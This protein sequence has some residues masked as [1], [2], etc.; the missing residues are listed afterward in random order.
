MRIRNKRIG[1]DLDSKNR[2]RLL[3]TYL[4]AS[5]YGK[6]KVYE[7]K[8]GYHIII[9][10]PWNNTNENMLIR[11]ILGDDPERLDYDELKQ[12][13]EL[14]EFIDTMFEVKKEKGKISREIEINPLSE[15]YL[16]QFSPIRRR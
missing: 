2:L 7:T 15:A 4:N 14:N 3:M 5:R 12:R 6:V 16:T 8:K 9:E 1:I 13:L 11:Q 10:R